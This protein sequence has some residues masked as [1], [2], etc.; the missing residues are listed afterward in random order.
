MI[1]F[2]CVLVIMA[3]TVSTT[4][5]V[6]AQTNNTGKAAANQSAVA[7]KR[8]EMVNRH[9]ESIKAK[10]PALYKE[11]VDLREKDPEKFRERMRGLHKAQMS[12]G[13]G[14]DAGV[15]GEHVQKGLEKIKEKDVAAYL[16]LLDLKEKD[17]R[18]FHVKFMEYMKKYGAH[19]KGSGQ[20]KKK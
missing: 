11:L 15:S 4:I 9:L 3:L 13:E 19:E 10:N 18:Q 14:L 6:D 20:K 16:E 5:R 7:E 17:P 2:N 1:R 8:K 12:E